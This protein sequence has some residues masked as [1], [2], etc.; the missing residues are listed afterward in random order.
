MSKIIDSSNYIYGKNPVK[1]ELKIIK[2]GTLFIQK[3]MNQSLISDILKKAESKNIEISYVDKEYFK[4]YF[5]DKNHQGIVLKINEEFNEQ[6]TEEDFVDEL[7]NSSIQKE[8][9]LI[10]DGIKDVGNFGAILRSALL[11]NVKYIILPKDNSVPVNDVVAKRS[12]GA[13]SQLKIVYVTNITRIIEFLKSNGYWIYGADKSGE[14]ISKVNYSSKLAIVLG[15]EG[16]GIR[17]LVKKNCDVIISIPTNDK[18]D[19]LNVSVS[20]GIILYELNSKIN[21]FENK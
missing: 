11:F 1:E 6:F 21:I 14:V 2:S 19:S 4:K 17:P 13:V 8:I 5:G 16:S 18:L 20:T 7:K 15:E 3:G 10:L 9:I 12:S